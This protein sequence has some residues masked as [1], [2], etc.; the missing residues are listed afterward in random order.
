VRSILDAGARAHSAEQKAI[1]EQLLFNALQMTG[2]VN[3]PHPCFPSSPAHL[4]PPAVEAGFSPDKASA[5]GSIVLETFD[6]SMAAF[7]PLEQAFDVFKEL[8]TKHCVQRPPWR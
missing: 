4:T 6:V 3:T 1:T 8:L 2:D 7:L 5:F